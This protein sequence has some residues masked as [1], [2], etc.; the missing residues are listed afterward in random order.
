MEVILLVSVLRVHF[1]YQ[2]LLNSGN[3]LVSYYINIV[4]ESVGIRGVD[5]RA[6]ISGGLQVC[7]QGRQRWYLFIFI[8]PL[9]SGT[10]QQP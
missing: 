9:R 6:T 4:L 8:E 2:Y 1:T 10:L 3:G 5:A 7:G